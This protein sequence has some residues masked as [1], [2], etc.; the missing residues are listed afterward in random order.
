MPARHHPPI[1]PRSPREKGRG[2]GRQ[3]GEVGTVPATG[4][5]PAPLPAIARD[6]PDPAPC[7]DGTGSARLAVI[8]AQPGIQLDPCSVCGPR[9]DQHGRRLSPGQQAV[10]APV[11][12]RRTQPGF[13]MIE[14]IMVIVLTGILGTMTAVFIVEPMRA[15]VDQSQR[16]ALVDAAEIALRRMGREIRAA[17]PNSVQVAP[18]G[19][20]LRFYNVVSGG[21]YRATGPHPDG[22]AAVLEFDRADDSFD[23]LGGFPGAADGTLANHFLVVYNLGTPGSDVHETGSTVITPASTIALATDAAT[24]ATRV[25]LGPA[26]RFG[27]QSPQQRIYLSD[28]PVAYACAADTLTR[29][30]VTVTDRVTSCSFR[31]QAGSETRSALVTLNLTLTHDGESVTL[32]RQVRLEN[33]P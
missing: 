2:E 27:W 7:P 25:T 4:K 13:T 22:A 8:P 18:D 15:Y 26:F 6:G 16:A 31:Y 9:Q 24:N 32:L 10:Q 14:L 19:R 3:P 21:R 17:V 29:N 20:S 23:V 11:L 33:L 1:E 30:G 12:S 28:G 5:S